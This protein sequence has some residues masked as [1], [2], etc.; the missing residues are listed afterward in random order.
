MLP[1][2]VQKYREAG[3]TIKTIGGNYYLYRVTSKRVP[4]K[5]NPVSI[6]EYLGKITEEGIIDARKRIHLIST[7]AKTLGKLVG[8]VPKDLAGIILLGLKDEWYFTKITPS[9]IKQLTSLGLYENEK[10][11]RG[12]EN[13]KKRHKAEGAGKNS[14]RDGG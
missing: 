11:A 10:L 3:T 5:K 13:G 2:W 1:E 9:Q 8:D 6:Q 7:P 12:K 4:G 14:E